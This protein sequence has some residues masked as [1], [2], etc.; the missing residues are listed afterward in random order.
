MEQFADEANET[1]YRVLDVGSGPGRDIQ[2]YLENNEGGGAKVQFDCVDMDAQ[3]I[4][5]AKQLC[6]DYETQIEFHLKNA[7]RY[8]TEKRYDFI[9]SGGLFDYLTDEQ[10]IF[11]LKRLRSM[12]KAGGRIIL[13][14]FSVRNPSRDYIEAGDWYLH[15]RTEDDLI[16]LAL[17]SGVNR[18]A[19]RIEQEETGVNLFLV[20]SA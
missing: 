2:E 4:A 18:D 13:G 12:S 3:A 8:R 6:Q 7:F 1:I 15:H 9:W 11:L 14:N 16:R 5:Y 20:I 19:V 17:A 10:F